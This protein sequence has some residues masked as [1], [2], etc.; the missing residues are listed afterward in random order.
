MSVCV[1]G[2]GRGK[3]VCCWV[4]DR[5]THIRALSLSLFEAVCNVVWL[6][7]GDLEVRGIDLP[8][9]AGHCRSRLFPLFRLF[10]CFLLVV[11]DFLG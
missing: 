4:R 3:G 6:L 11:V 9:F 7:C 10:P 1:C 2:G 8:T 5:Q